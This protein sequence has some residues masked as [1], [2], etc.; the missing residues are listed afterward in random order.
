M[1][2]QQGERKR[3]VDE[4]QSDLTGGDGRSLTTIKKPQARTTTPQSPT[5]IRVVVFFKRTREMT[6][7]FVWS[8]LVVVV[9]VD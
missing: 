1:T 7:W 5:T 3:S 8:E 9:F 6:D 4:Q 2:K